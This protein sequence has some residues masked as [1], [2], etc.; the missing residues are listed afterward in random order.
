[1]EHGC[2]VKAPGGKLP[3]VFRYP[4]AV[5]PE[6]N[7]LAQAQQLLVRYYLWAT[8]GPWRLNSRLHY[9]LIDRKVALPEFAGTKQ[10][11]GAVSVRAVLLGSRALAST[12]IA[13]PQVL[14][15]AS[16]CRGSDRSSVGVYSARRAGR[17]GLASSNPVTR[18]ACRCWD[19][20][21]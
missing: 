11:P 16:D 1:V 18:R 19:V 15:D 2:L 3:G 12:D 5:A 13:C 7:V 21:P 20:R 17:G 9:D 8:D 10:T 14:V 4:A 6:Q